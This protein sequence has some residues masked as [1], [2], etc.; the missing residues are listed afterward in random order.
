[1]EGYF[2][3]LDFIHPL[4]DKESFILG[5]HNLWFGKNPQPDS[6]IALYLSLLSLGALIRAREQLPLGGLTGFE[7]SRKLFAEAQGYLN[8]GV[9]PTAWRLYKH[10]I[11]WYV[12]FPQRRRETILIICVSRPRSARMNSR[13]TVGFRLF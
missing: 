4:I 1:M 7:W 10:C 13:L 2:E 12:F 8:I 6:F 3:Y 9:L 5:A 11:L